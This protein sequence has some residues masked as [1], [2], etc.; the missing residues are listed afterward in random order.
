MYVIL[1]VIYLAANQ[2]NAAAVEVEDLATCL[3]AKQ[4]VID[5]QVDYPN[6]KV[7]KTDCFVINSL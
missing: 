5:K 3:E 1:F 4:L 7:L 6:I 2:I